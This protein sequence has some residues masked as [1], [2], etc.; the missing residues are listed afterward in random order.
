MIYLDNSATTKPFPEVVQSYSTVAMEFFGNPSSLHSIGGQAERLLTQART[1]IADLLG[2]KSNEIYFTSGGTE[3]N[4]F[5]LKGAA[6]AFKSRG[7]HIITTKIEH[8]SIHKVMQQLEEDGF[9]IT[10]LPVDEDGVVSVEDIKKS[11]CKDTSI[12]SIMHVNNEIGSIQPIEEIGAM[13]KAQKQSI[14]FHVD[15]VQA[16][17]KL[18]V[19]LKKANIDVYTISAHKFHGLKGNGVL[20]IKEGINL[21]PLLA[22]GGQEK[23]YRSGTEN[24]AGA[25]STAKALRMQLANQMQKTDKLVELNQYLRRNLEKMENV[26]IHS[27]LDKSIPHIINFSVLGVKAEVFIH[28]LEK[29]H[30]Y[31]STT[32]A[33]S[34]KSNIVSK[35]LTSIGVAKEIAE[36]SFRISLQYDNTLE[37]MQITINKIADTIKWLRGVMK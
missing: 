16:A 32:S 7:Q 14:L 13:I 21:S 19:D 28:A 2:V 24:V 8:D 34:S 22:G 18:P 6:A 20:Y 10:Y 31:L 5:A 25:V 15:G 11:I 29:H 9:R 26:R 30:I 27:P 35:T 17:G 4:N 3:G 36:S 37:E 23:N 1:Q 12:V 33:C